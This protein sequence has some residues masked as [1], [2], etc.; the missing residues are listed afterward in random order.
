MVA[1]T[2]K[3]VTVGTNPNFALYDPA[4]KEVYVANEGSKSVSAISSTTYAVKT[5]TVG[6]EPLLITY[7]PTTK[8]LYVEN[9][10][11]SIS[12]ISTANT[13]VK[14]ITFPAGVFPISQAYSPANGDV[15]VLCD[16]TTGSELVQINSATYA[17][18]AVVLPG[19]ALFV[20]YDNASSSLVVSSPSANEVTAVSSTNVA[21]TVTLAKGFFPTWMVY[22]PHDSDLYITDAGE[23]AHG[24]TK[25]GNVSVLSSANTIIATVKVG[26]F[27][28]L[29]WYD[30][31]NFDIYEMNT[32]KPSKP[33]PV[34]TVSVIGT[35]N[36][37]VKTLTVGKYAA[38]ASYDPKN[39]E[40][41]IAC[42]GSNLTYAISSGNA[43]VAKVVT[44]QYA[45]AAEYDPKLGEMLAVGFATFFGAPVA[46]TLV[47]LIPSSN[48]G[49]STVT[50]G[51][52]PAAG[53][54]YDPTDSGVWIVNGGTTTVSVIL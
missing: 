33:F 8:A 15:Y 16:T 27:P 46:N 35:G 41:Y 26:S 51:T 2:T 44:K 31:A 14:T 39:S 4:T 42:P 3:T 43:I 21:T 1:V 18:K 20:T 23:T 50:L 36:T 13:V 25:T 48:T 22:N 38:V 47:T 11:T 12:V 34:S 37:V 32:G 7:N 28:T 52:G 53:G 30:P 10:E 19:A 49:T 5:I 6:T 24:V 17:Q 40:M 45:T 29:G 54:T 9:F